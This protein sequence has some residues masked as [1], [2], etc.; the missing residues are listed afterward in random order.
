MAESPAAAKPD[1]SRLPHGG[2]QLTADEWRVEFARFYDAVDKAQLAD[3][4]GGDS[5]VA[6]CLWSAAE[7]RALAAYLEGLGVHV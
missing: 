2:K 1:E 7:T 6:V 4:T 5:A 3:N